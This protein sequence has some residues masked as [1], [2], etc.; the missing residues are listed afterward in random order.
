VTSLFLPRRTPGVKEFGVPL[1]GEDA[2]RARG[3]GPRESR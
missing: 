3:A 1:R 2:C